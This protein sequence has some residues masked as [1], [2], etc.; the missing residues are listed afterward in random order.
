MAEF[1]ANGLWLLSSALPRQHLGNHGCLDPGRRSPLCSPG[2]TVVHV[3]E[4]GKQEPM[5]APAP[6]KK[7]FRLVAEPHHINPGG[8]LPSKPITQG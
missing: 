6:R 7:G 4:K 8:E 5:H 3:E 1:E 2:R